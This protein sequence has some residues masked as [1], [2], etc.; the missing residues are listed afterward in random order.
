MLEKPLPRGFY[1]LL[2]FLIL[3][4]IIIIII[5]L[6]A[7]KFSISRLSFLTGRVFMSLI[8]I[9]YLVKI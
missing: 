6:Y 8:V 7:L 5:F 1:N 4:Y 2:L 3:F 9:M